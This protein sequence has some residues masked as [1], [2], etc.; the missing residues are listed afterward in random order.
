MQKMLVE[1]AARQVVC[2]SSWVCAD[3]S[4][5]RLIGIRI[6]ARCYGDQNDLLE[7]PTLFPAEKSATEACRAPVLIM[8]L[9]S[10]IC[11][12]RISC[13]EYRQLYTNTIE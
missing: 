10:S 4:L 13:L 11:C 9:D 5:E 12:M 1:L 3:H 2:V 6:I 8:G 7:Q